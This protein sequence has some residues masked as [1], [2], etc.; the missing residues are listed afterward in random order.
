LRFII[1]PGQKSTCGSLYGIGEE[2]AAEFDLCTSPQQF[3]NNDKVPTV[4]GGL[5]ST[6]KEAAP[7][8]IW[9]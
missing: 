2:S 6:T 1:I 8:L 7:K 4:S 9:A 3:L 5:Q